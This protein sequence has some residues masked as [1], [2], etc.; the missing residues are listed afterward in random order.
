MLFHRKES[1]DD[2]K[3]YI[4]IIQFMSDRPKSTERENQV[5]KPS[6]YILVHLKINLAC[7]Y[8]KCLE[9]MIIFY[10]FRGETQLLVPKRSPIFYIFRY[11]QI[12]VCYI[13]VTN[14]IHDYVFLCVVHITYIHVSLHGKVSD[15]GVLSISSIDIDR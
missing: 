15:V 8:C 9:F 1:L 12:Y 3:D 4:P 7:L 2:T 14:N 5:N 10:I 6:K 13:C 11:I